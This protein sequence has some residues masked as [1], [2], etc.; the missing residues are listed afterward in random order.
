M[1]NGDPLDDLSD[2]QVVEAVELARKARLET[3]RRAAYELHRRRWI[4]EK[5]GEQLGIA[6][7]T[8]YRWAQEYAKDNELGFP[9]RRT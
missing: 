5:I 8:A 9:L 4:W 7:S 3:E 1:S 6:Q 2:G